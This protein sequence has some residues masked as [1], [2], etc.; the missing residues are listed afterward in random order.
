VT[1]VTESTDDYGHSA[2][3]HVSVDE[4]SLTLTIGY[5][6]GGG[7]QSTPLS[8]IEAKALGEA[9]VAAAERKLREK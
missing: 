1:L 2:T 4:D 6:Y 5:P 7:R 9:L 3:K 8:P